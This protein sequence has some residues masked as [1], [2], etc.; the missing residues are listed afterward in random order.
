MKESGTGIVLL[1]SLGGQIT[2]RGGQRNAGDKVAGGG[3][4]G[5]R[6]PCAGSSRQCC[7]DTS[8]ILRGSRA[9]TP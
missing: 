9:T 3:G 5:R 6:Q 8:Y 2:W 4:A 1:Y 7:H